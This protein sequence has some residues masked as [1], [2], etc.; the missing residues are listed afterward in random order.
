MEEMSH[1]KLKERFETF[2]G[3]L[4]YNFKAMNSLASIRLGLEENKNFNAES[5]FYD[6]TEAVSGMIGAYK[7][8]ASLSDQ[9][10]ARYTLK[11]EDLER[12]NAGVIVGMQYARKFGYDNS[13][14]M[15]AASR[16]VFDGVENL[17]RAIADS[18]NPGFVLENVATLHDLIRY[19]HQKGLDEM[20]CPAEVDADAQTYKFGHL[21]FNL[22]NLGDGLTSN[23]RSVSRKQIS[24]VPLE[25]MIKSYESFEHKKFPSRE[26]I[27]AVVDREFVN[28]HLKLGCHS[29]DITSLL[30]DIDSFVEVNYNETAFS[31]SGRRREYVARCFEHLG[32]KVKQN[33]RQLKASFRDRSKEPTSSVLREATRVLFTCLDLDLSGYLDSDEDVKYTFDYFVSGGANPKTVLKLKH[34]TDAILAR[35]FDF[36]ET[37]AQLEH[38]LKPILQSVD[39]GTIDFIQRNLESRLRSRFTKNKNLDV[40]VPSILT[41]EYRTDRPVNLIKIGSAMQTYTVPYIKLKEMIEKETK[42]VN[43]FYSL[44]ENY[45]MPDVLKGSIEILKKNIL[46]NI[47]TLEEQIIPSITPFISPQIEPKVNKESHFKNFID[48]LLGKKSKLNKIK[49]KPDDNKE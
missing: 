16:K 20:F 17:S 38:T 11:L 34:Y 33:K 45:H 6:V 18:A 25:E 8:L 29:T 10:V 22:K 13:S 19:V 42:I 47:P 3:L 32:F 46:D 14:V 4:A 49:K 23:A 40:L 9:E 15:D 2:K 31:N 43:K 41:G 24:C 7:E 36:T 39:A 30:S 1:E 44:S 28:A 5:S 48:N 27:N 37:I 21:N 35:D 26:T 12:K